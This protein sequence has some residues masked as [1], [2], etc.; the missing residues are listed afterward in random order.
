MA[1]SCWNKTFFVAGSTTV[2]RM[3]YCINVLMSAK[4]RERERDLQRSTTY[5]DLG[6]I[7]NFPTIFTM[8]DPRAGARPD[9]A[10]VLVDELRFD[11][12]D[13]PAANAAR[14]RA[15]FTL[16]AQHDAPD[17]LNRRVIDGRLENLL[18]RHP[19]CHIDREAARRYG[20]CRPGDRHLWRSWLATG[21]VERGTERRTKTCIL[22]LGSTS[23]TSRASVVFQFPLHSRPNRFASINEMRG[24]KR[25]D[26][27][28]QDLGR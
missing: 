19:Q 14:V 24:H 10:R 2:T 28:G 3:K 21:V 16:C 13:L 17:D 5:F 9:D 18:A 1:S 20:L 15:L 8:N 11:L 6:D 23:D 7:T 26:G 12:L 25:A 4:K 22:V 27:L